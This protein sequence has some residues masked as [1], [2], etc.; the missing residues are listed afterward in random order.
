MERK[1]RTDLHPN[2]RALLRAGAALTAVGALGSLTRTSTLA[3]Q[4]APQ[5]GSPEYEAALKITGGIKGVFQSPALDAMSVSGDNVNHL[6]LIQLKNWLNSF[7]FSYKEAPED[8]H[9]LS[10]TFASANLLTYGDAVW[11]KYK[12]G[13]KYEIT[14]PTTGAPAIRNLFWPS[15][16]GPDAPKDITAKN[17]FYQDTGIEV[18]Q[19]RGTIFLTC[20]NTLSGH[21]AAAVADGRAPADMEAADV[22]T[23]IAANLVPG[24][25]LVP[26]VVG[27]VSRAQMAGYSL[28]FIPKFSL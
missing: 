5:L 12:L 8:L 11:E 26:S 14:D 10:T 2:R 9:T 7:Q 18:L 19:Q 28:I 4:S 3:A 15:R 1:D 16:F 24:A 22:A 20:N 23:D 27:E 21:A 6:Q 25:V 17:N 13:E